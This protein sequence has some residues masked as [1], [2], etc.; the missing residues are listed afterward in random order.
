M[1]SQRG[2]QDRQLL[3]GLEPPE[4]LGGLQ[5]GGSGPAQRHLGILPAFDVAADLPNGAVH[6]FDD[7]RARQRPAQFDRQA[8]A[9]DGEDFVDAFQDAGGDAGGFP[10]QAAGEIAD[11]L[12]RLLGIIE[13]LDCV[14]R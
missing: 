14:F 13:F 8:E 5:H 1:S 3:A 11:Q 4:A 2:P 12:F 6:V 10:F 9:G 7:V